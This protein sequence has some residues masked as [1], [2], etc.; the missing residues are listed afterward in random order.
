V[1]DGQ[2]AHFIPRPNY[3]PAL[4]QMH[5]RGRLQRHRDVQVID[6]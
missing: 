6:Q 1:Y 2:V 3:D 4:L 5:V